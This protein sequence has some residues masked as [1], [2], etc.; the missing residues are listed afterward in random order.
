[1]SR[2]M[3]VALVVIL[4][5]IAGVLAYQ[6]YERDQNSLQIEVGPKGVKVDPPG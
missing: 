5:A 3:L 6:A 1:M 2:T 4:A